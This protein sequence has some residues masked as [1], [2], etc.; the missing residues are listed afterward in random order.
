MQTDC[1]ENQQVLQSYFA[2]VCIFKQ[3]FNCKVSGPAGLKMVGTEW[4]GYN[5][6]LK[7]LKFSVRVQVSSPFTAPFLNLGPT[8]L[9]RGSAEILSRISSQW[10]HFCS[11]PQQ[12]RANGRKATFRHNTVPFQPIGRVLQIPLSK[13]R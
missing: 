8:H 3:P 13:T 9:S 10:L 6:E 7:P 4:W 2:Q 12:L 11:L 1:R 5:R